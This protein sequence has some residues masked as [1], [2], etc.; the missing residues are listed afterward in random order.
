MTLA[1]EPLYPSK[2]QAHEL[3]P[4]LRD[5]FGEY[6]ILAN[7]SAETV[8]RALRVLRSIEVPESEVGACLGALEVE[9]EV[10]S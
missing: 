1:P 5:L 6:P 7:R 3:V 9:G 4:E 2:P 8:R 10:L